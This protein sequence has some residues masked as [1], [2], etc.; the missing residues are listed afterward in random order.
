MTGARRAACRNPEIPERAFGD[1][2]ARAYERHGHEDHAQG[3]ASGAASFPRRRNTRLNARG[4]SGGF[5]DVYIE[6]P[7][8]S[9]KLRVPVSCPLK[10]SLW[11][12]SMLEVDQDSDLPHRHCACVQ[13]CAQY[14]GSSRSLRRW[15]SA[16]FR[17]LLVTQFQ[18][19]GSAPASDL[20][21]FRLLA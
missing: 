14:P 4:R 6:I 15:T 20:V 18:Q 9:C 16:R 12:G 3:R 21:R 8:T 11:D 7:S 1:G 13:A 10:N 2:H 19:T 17:S 5:G